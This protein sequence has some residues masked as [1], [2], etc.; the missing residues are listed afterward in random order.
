M[1][2][3]LIAFLVAPLVVP[4]LLVLYP[5]ELSSTNFK[6]PLFVVP[7]AI[8]AYMAVWMLGGPVYLFLRARHWTGFWVS[9]IVGFA[10]GAVMWLVVGMAFSLMLGHSLAGSFSLVA[11]PGFSGGMLWPAGIAGAATGAVLWRI[12]RPDR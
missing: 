9:P 11:D 8:I 5:R 3:T 12:A 6:D 4:A 1:N 10:F 2:R 7:G